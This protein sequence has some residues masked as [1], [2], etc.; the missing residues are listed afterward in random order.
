MGQVRLDRQ[1]YAKAASW[2]Q[3]AADQ[4][5]PQAQYQLALLLKDGK[6]VNQDKIRGLCLDAG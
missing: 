4:G 5:L 1:D 3:K 6:G 2:F